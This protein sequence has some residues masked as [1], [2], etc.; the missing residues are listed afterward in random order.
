MHVLVPL[1]VHEDDHFT[2]QESERNNAL[3]TIVLSQI[4][5]GDGEV[6]PD[7]FRPLKVQPMRL[8]IPT[9]FGF[10]PGGYT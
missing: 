8:D 6:V 5:A 9:A 1:D 10:V 4:L 3:F 2:I 7:G